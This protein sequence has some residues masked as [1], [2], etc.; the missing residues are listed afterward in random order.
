MVGARFGWVDSVGFWDLFGFGDRDEGE[1]DPRDFRR[2]PAGLM[3]HVACGR[4]LGLD[5]I[6]ANRAHLPVTSGI[7]RLYPLFRIFDLFMDNPRRVRSNTSRN[8]CGDSGF[9]Q[10][11]LH[12]ES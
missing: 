5:C 11:V 10:G 4:I 12:G 2:S 1:S 6:R 8:R 3:E 7:E 9:G